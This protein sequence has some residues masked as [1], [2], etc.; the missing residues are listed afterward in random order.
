[1]T[2][3]LQGH[4]EYV[5]AAYVVTWLFFG[6]YTLSLWYRARQLAASNSDS[7]PA[8]SPGGSHE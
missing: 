4:W 1:M 7:S 2:G 8:P 5:T 6:G 3:E